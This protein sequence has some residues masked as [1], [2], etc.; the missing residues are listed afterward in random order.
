[1]TVFEFP[2]QS[3]DTHSMRELIDAI[4]ARK[5]NALAA[6]DQEL[7]GGRPGSRLPPSGARSEPPHPPATDPARLQPARCL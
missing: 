5:A 2:P 6:I 4:E 3:A 1:D 7:A